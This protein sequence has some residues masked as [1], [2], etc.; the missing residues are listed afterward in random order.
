MV[1]VVSHPFV[2]ISTEMS[3]VFRGVVSVKSYLASY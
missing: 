1:D 3:P 2:R